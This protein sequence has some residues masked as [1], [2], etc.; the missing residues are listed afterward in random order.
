MEGGKDAAND[1]ARRYLCLGVNM[2]DEITIESQV[3]Y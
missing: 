1:I 2:E 3:D